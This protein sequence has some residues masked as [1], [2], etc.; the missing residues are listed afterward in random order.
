MLV[1]LI[2]TL[3]G[4][5]AWANGRVLETAAGL[6]P[7]RYFARLGGSFDSVHDTLVHIVGA[8]W[9]WLR[10]WLGESP[11]AIFGPADFEG[12]ADLRRRW[13]EVKTQAY[14]GGLDE[15]ALG[16]LLFYRDTRGVEHTFSLWQTLVHQV[17][18]AAQHRS[19]AAM[20][21]IRLGHSPGELDFVRYLE[22]R[23][24]P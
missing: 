6:D 17:N 14:L 10:R 23:P 18:H 9:V 16:R 20:M 1:D 12:I 3:Y 21:L 2:K 15:A 5:N 11:R 13:E 7:D 8:Q 19:E 4:Y 24:Q 22:R